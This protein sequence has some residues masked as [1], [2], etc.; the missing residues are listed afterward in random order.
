MFRSSLTLQLRS[1]DELFAALEGAATVADDEDVDQLTHGLQCA[2]ILERVEPAD[3][4][5]QIA[6]LVHDL[7]AVLAPGHP[8]SHASTGAAAVEKL[9]G[10]RVAGLV[11]R[12]DDAK[13]FLVTTDPRYRHR[14][15]ERSL[16]TLRVQGGLLDPEERA[17]L[18]GYADLD[19]C[20]TLR[21]ADDM[22]KTPGV[23][24]PGLAHWRT[25]LERLGRSAA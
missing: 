17:A 25:V 11:G 3:I 15:S 18:L 16:E 13:R 7:G 1:T 14:L 10:H 19:A 20:L 23:H 9:L 5:L 24:V 6:G 22:A 21:R 12:H 8:E 2:A 4:E